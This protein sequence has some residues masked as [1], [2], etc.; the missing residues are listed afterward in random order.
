[1][2]IPEI[3]R[4]DW[5]KVEK[6]DDLNYLRGV[7]KKVGVNFVGVK[8]EDLRTK[9]LAE[10]RI[11]RKPLEHKPIGKRDLAACEKLPSKSAQ[12]QYLF[13]KGYH[14]AVISAYTKMHITN[15]YACL[16]RAGLYTTG[17]TIKKAVIAKIKATIAEKQKVAENAKA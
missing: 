1:M 3:T 15:V 16:R 4:I 7:A 13:N 11:G 2:E 17:K 12:I 10:R 14:P 9:V 8:A 6:T 5:R